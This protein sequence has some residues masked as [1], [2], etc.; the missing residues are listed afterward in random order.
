MAYFL[1]S[2]LQTFGS[3]EYFGSWQVAG[4]I[5]SPITLLIKKNKK[6]LIIWR[7][8]E[9]TVEVWRQSYLSH[10]VVCARISLQMNKQMGWDVGSVEMILVF[11][12]ICQVEKQ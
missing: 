9:K 12:F 10:I 7:K 1:S 4:E 11:F 6:N 3:K 8:F 5:M 2:I